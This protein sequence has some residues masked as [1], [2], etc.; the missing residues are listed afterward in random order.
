MIDGNLAMASQYENGDEVAQR[1]ADASAARPRYLQKTGHQFFMKVYPNG[2]VLTVQ[3][4][5]NGVASILYNPSTENAIWLD[6][7][8]I[9]R[10][11]WEKAYGE[12]QWRL[13]QANTIQ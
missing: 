13:T 12:A 4:F 6:A 3:L 8:D 10:D 1:A 7:I 2:S 9:T 11:A 5:E